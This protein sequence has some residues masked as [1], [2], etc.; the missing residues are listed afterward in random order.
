MTTGTLYCNSDISST[1][2]RFPASGGYFDKLND[3]S[4]ATYLSM[5]GAVEKVGRFG[6]ENFPAG[7]STITQ[8]NVSPRGMFHPVT[9]STF[10]LAVKA[11]NGAN[12]L[13]TL[14]WAVQNLATEDIYTQLGVQSLTGLSLSKAQFDSLEIELRMVTNGGSSDFIYCSEL[15]FTAEYTEEALAVF[16]AKLRVSSSLDLGM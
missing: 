7:E 12:L 15:N 2:T 5:K 8:L 11:Y 1:L 6:L 3:S 10:T 9:G 13:G 4:D 14:T 16:S